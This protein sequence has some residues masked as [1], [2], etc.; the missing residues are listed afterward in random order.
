MIPQRHGQLDRSITNFAL[1]VSCYKLTRDNKF[2]LATP[3]SRSDADELG[4]LG[5]WNIFIIPTCIGGWLEQLHTR[6]KGR[7]VRYEGGRRKVECSST[8]KC[9]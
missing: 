2:L 3:W 6:Y 5:T 9:F 8:A 7:S 1:F 4:R